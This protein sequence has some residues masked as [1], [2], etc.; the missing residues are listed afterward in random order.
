MKYRIL[1][2]SNKKGYIFVV[3][4]KE[5]VNYSNTMRRQGK[6]SQLE[7]PMDDFGHRASFASVS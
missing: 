6:Q 3:P 2:I 7:V 4:D 5:N 1:R